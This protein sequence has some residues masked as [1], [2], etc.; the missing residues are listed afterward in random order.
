MGEEITI[1]LD[2]DFDLSFLSLANIDLRGVATSLSLAPE[3]LSRGEATE[4][5]GRG[6]KGGGPE[7]DRTGISASAFSIFA[8]PCSRL[9]HIGYQK[10]C[11]YLSYLNKA[12][13]LSTNT[14]SLSFNCCS[15][16]LF[17]F[18]LSSIFSTR[19]TNAF[20]L[21]SISWAFLSF[22]ADLENCELFD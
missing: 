9:V 21:S 1:A 17:S 6:A 8:K 14:A 13:S 4:L 22:S 7:N 19:S 10:C 11:I 12:V 2:F 3:L 16:L 5:E 18:S 20:S 15:L